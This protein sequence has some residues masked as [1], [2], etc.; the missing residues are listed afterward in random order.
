MAHR[1]L[2]PGTHMVAHRHSDLSSVGSSAHFMDTPSARMYKQ[3]IHAQKIISLL[4]KMVHVFVI[5]APRKQRQI[6]L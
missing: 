6:D 1:G 5:P 4:E 2:V 3:N